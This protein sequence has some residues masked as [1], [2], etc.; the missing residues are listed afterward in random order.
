MSVE[1]TGK[2]KV[3]GNLTVA[4]VNS[5]SSHWEGNRKGQG[6]TSASFEPSLFKSDCSFVVCSFRKRMDQKLEVSCCCRVVKNILN[7]S[8]VWNK[9]SS[10]PATWLSPPAL[11]ISHTAQEVFLLPCTVMKL[12]ASQFSLSQAQTEVLLIYSFSYRLTRQCS[13]NIN[14]C[15]WFAAALISSWLQ[16]TICL[17][18]FYVHLC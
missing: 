5:K 14:C 7:S 17:G 15:N 4:I 16:L 12:E 9:A 1:N 6:L 18:L 2:S 11:L 10:L 8:T 3:Q 13:T